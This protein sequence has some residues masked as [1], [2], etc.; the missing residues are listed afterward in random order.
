MEPIKLSPGNK[1]LSSWGI[2]IQ[3]P[4]S[5]LLRG[6]GIPSKRGRDCVSRDTKRASNSLISPA[7]VAMKRIRNITLTEGEPGSWIAKDRI[8]K[9]G[10]WVVAPVLAYKIRHGVLSSLSFKY[11]YGLCIYSGCFIRILAASFVF[12]TYRLLLKSYA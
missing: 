10:R 12:V 5:L 3:L 2:N 8:A 7:S 6:P 4:S 1:A 11:I 9:K